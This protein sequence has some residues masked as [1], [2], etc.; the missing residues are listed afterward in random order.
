M[1]S[2]ASPADTPRVIAVPPDKLVV[3][4][5]YQARERLDPQHV[6]RLRNTDPKAWPPLLV[7]PYPNR[8]GCYLIID[9]AHRFEAGKRLADGKRVTRF[10]CTVRDGLTYADSF[11]ANRNHP[12]TLSTA[13]RKQFAV[14]LHELKPDLSMRTLALVSGLTHPTVSA[15]IAREQGHAGSGCAAT[16]IGRLLQLLRRAHESRE[17]SGLLGRGGMEPAYVAKTILESRDRRGT[18]QALEFWLP[19]LAEGLKIA[20]EKMTGQR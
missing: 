3:D 11:E 20:R 5:S 7:T 2:E 4:E 8:L 15:A 9:G 10:P 18:L 14:W 1:A 13:E 19:R 17:G 6:E 16:H 12:L